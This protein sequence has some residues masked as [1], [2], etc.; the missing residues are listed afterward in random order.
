MPRAAAGLRPQDVGRDSVCPLLSAG[1]ALSVR[2]FPAAKTRSRTLW[3][4]K[5]GGPTRW[6]R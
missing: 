3:G 5:V 2:V 6:L 1:T 4:A